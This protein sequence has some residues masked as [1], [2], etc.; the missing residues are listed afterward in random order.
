MTVGGQLCRRVRGRGQ[1]Y[2]AWR[3]AA[4][5][6][7]TRLYVHDW[8]ARVWAR[9]PGACDVR[10]VAR[11]LAVLP[12]GTPPL[13]IG[14]ASDLHIGPTTPRALLERAFDTLAAARLDVLALGGDYVFLDATERSASILAD[15][16]R[17]VPARV[18]VAVLGNHDLW[19]DHPRLE[20]ALADEGVRVLV[21]EGVYLPEPHGGVYLA[22]LDDPWTG[23]PDAARAFDGGAAARVRIA[24]VHSPDGVPMI[25]DRGVDLVIAGHTHGGQVALPGGAPLWV[26]GPLGPA[27]PSG[28]FT[29]RDGAVLFVSRGLG[30]VEIPVRL[31]APPDVGVLTL[32]ARGS[33]RE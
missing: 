27:Y 32:E 12:S 4:E 6:V 22:G 25:E 24:V 31:H 18:K 1:H 20:R 13:R 2:A 17:R 10:T 11:T 28:F 21:N 9:V 15:L 5:A 16:V 33:P 19:T 26:P 23:A 3:G 29:L 14:F 30:G 7:A 8:P